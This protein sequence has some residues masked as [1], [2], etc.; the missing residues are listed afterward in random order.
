[1][2]KGVKRLLSI[3]TVCLAV[4]SII[5]IVTGGTSKLS[6]ADFLICVSIT[7]VYM[8]CSKLLRK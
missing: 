5:N 1:M 7:C 2:Y 8:I 4:A 6:N 3:L